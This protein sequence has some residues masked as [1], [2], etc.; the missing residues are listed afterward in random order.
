MSMCVLET[1]RFLI[2]PFQPSDLPEAAAVLDS[3]FGAQ[4]IERRAEW[5]KWTVQN[6][7]ALRR[8]GQPPYGDV[9]VTRK[10]DGL[11]VGSV[12]LVP[13]LGPFESLG[14]FCHNSDAPARGFTAEVG[15]FWEWRRNIEGPESP[16]TPPRH[17]RPG[18]SRRCR[19]IAWSR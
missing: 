5:L 14:Y 6:Y 15:L 2:R 13:C 1:E 16:R 4:P 10:S 12:G 19:S 3:C 8:L 7:E 11:L 9:A 18:C 17:S